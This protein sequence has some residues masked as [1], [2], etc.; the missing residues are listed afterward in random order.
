MDQIVCCRSLPKSC[1]RV[2][3]LSVCLYV[4]HSCRKLKRKIK[5]S[6]HLFHF[7]FF[8][9]FVS[10]IFFDMQFLL[11]SMLFFVNFLTYYLCWSMTYFSL[12]NCYFDT[13]YAPFHNCKYFKINLLWSIFILFYF[14]LFYFILFYFILFYW[15]IYLFCPRVRDSSNRSGSS[16]P[17]R[18]AGLLSPFLQAETS[19]LPAEYCKKMK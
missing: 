11:F 15:S 14:I 2:L 18:P 13:L 6:K 19:N 1:V 8:F 3:M 7:K 4:S 5:H 9:L 10:F 17:D 16:I 12:I